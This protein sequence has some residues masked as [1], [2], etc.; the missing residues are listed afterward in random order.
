MKRSIL[1]A[2]SAALLTPIAVTFAAPPGAP[3][4][5]QHP[6]SKSGINKLMRVPVSGV[7]IN[8]R[9]NPHIKNPYAGSRQAVM[10]GKKLFH[11]MNCVG[12]HAPEGGGGMGPAL[13]DNV[14]IY[15]GSPENIYLTIQHGRPN[16]MP[17]WGG[18]LP[19]QAIWYL[20][21]YVKT[22]S[23]KPASSYKQKTKLSG[24]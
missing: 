10:M 3:P 24:Q 8:P 16:G 9:Q 6:M 4:G 17:A 14:W 19:P 22:L 7:V 13:S 1:L 5:E 20:V 15:G 12:C 23:Q 18:A 2:L 21:T 11:A